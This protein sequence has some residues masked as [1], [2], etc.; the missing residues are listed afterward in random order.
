[1]VRGRYD[2]LYEENG[3]D[4]P[5]PHVRW[6]A[7]RNMEA[8]LELMASG[9]INIESMISHRFTFEKAQQAYDVILE[10]SNISIG[11]ILR[12]NW[13]HILINAFNLD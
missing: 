7:Q 9:K 1:M 5:F 3:Q 11:I 4:Y 6:T 2:P 10:P 8:V 12:G 13:G